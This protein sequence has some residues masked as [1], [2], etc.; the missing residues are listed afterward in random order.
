M[1]RRGT[2]PALMAV[3]MMVALRSVSMERMGEERRNLR[4]VRA[5]M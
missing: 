2:T 1:M 4:S 5:W 3:S